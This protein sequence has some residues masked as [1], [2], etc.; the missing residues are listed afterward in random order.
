[1]VGSHKVTGKA[2]RPRRQAGWARAQ[3]AAPPSPEGDASSG[4]PADAV[5]STNVHSRAVSI[6]KQILTT[7]TIIAIARVIAIIGGIKRIA[8]NRMM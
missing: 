1:M 5:Q 8:P 6:S 4:G 3:A 7:R 2:A